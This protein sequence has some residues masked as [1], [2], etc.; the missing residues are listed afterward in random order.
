MLDMVGLTPDDYVIDLGSGDGRIV[1]AAA[2]RGARALGIEYNSELVEQSKVTSI[3]EGVSNKASF[4]SLDLFEADISAAS[5]L[6][7]FLSPEMILKLHPKLLKLKPGTRVVSNTFTAESWAPDE[8]AKLQE[9]AGSKIF[10]TAHLWIVPAKVDGIWTFAAGVLALK[11]NFQTI[12]GTL[13]IAG[14]RT[15]II[16][17]KLRGEQ[18]TFS[19][20]GSDYLGR[21]AGD[22][23]EGTVTHDGLTTAWSATRASKS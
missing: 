23:I 20:N 2:K 3:K 18:L 19:A 10:F 7:M 17:A 12:D 6:T 14:I 8:T 13:A 21:V 11:Q 22:V 16:N 4:L 5:V 9:N 1:I 15:P